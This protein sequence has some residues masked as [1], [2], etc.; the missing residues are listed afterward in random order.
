VFGE[1]IYASDYARSYSSAE[2]KRHGLKR[3]FIINAKLDKIQGIAIEKNLQD[4]AGEDAKKP[5]I[6][7]EYAKKSEDATGEAQQG[8]GREKQQGFP[9]NSK[10]PED[11]EAVLSFGASN[12]LS[13]R[14]TQYQDD[15]SCYII[16]CKYDGETRTIN[17][18]PLTATNANKESIQGAADTS[19]YLKT[20]G[21]SEKDIEKTID[22]LIYKRV[23]GGWL[24]GNKWRSAF[25]IINAGAFS[26]QK[27]GALTAEL[28][29]MYTG[30]E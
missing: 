25:S 12:E 21:I 5:D 26:I 13:F 30:G 28:V 16:R 27:A 17:V 14:F 19:C 4:G 7:G 11:A 2:G 10:L 15:G 9:L 22:R 29:E 8:S 1:M 23:I 6:I 24:S 18:E 20:H 3:I